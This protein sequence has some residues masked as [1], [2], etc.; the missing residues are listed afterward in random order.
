LTDHPIVFFDGHCGLCNSTVDW[1]LR[2]DKKHVFRF[3]PL[4]GTTAGD[5][6]KGMDEG[7]LL[8]SFWLKDEEG[9]H[10]RST[11]MLRILKRLGGFVSLGYAAIVVP[12]VV[13]DGVYNWIAKRR[14]KIWGRSE[15]CRIP[16]AEERA[17]FLP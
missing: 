5:L 2:K 14:Y 4:Q 16:T 17:Y 8:R 6:F 3:A 9:L 7:E 11:A 12:K 1:I 13:R 10:R 15:T